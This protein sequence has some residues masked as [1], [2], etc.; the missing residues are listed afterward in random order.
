M[1]LDTETKQPLD[2]FNIVS[3]EPTYWT[4]WILYNNFQFNVKYD[5]ETSK[6][7][8]IITKLP[9]VMYPGQKLPLDVKIDTS[10]TIGMYVKEIP[11]FTQKTSK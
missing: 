7:I 2:K 9:D 3:T 5:I 1:I 6:G 4:N 10:K 8:Q 11:H